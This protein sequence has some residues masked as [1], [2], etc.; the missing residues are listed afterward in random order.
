MSPSRSLP[1][2]RLAK[3]Q[4]E[5]RWVAKPAYIKKL[6]T[7]DE[8]AQLLHAAEHELAHAADPATDPG[9]RYR[10]AAQAALKLAAIVLRA[11]EYESSPSLDPKLTFEALLDLFGPEGRQPAKNFLAHYRRS[12]RTPEGKRPAAVERALA[13]ILREAGAFRESVLEWLEATRRHLLPAA[14]S[15]EEGLEGRQ[16]LLF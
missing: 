11:S 6:C 8:I 7:S 14:K 4:G 3:V 2:T 1:A 9:A 13:E 10:A 12:R 5:R 15:G 16:G